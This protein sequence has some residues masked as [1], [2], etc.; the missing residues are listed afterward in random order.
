MPSRQR[1]IRKV[2]A[3]QEW[4]DQYESDDPCLYDQ[5][6]TAYVARG[7]AERAGAAA[8]ALVDGDDALDR[9]KNGPA[10][11]VDAWAKAQTAIRRFSE[12]YGAATGGVSKFGRALG[13]RYGKS[14][15]R[16]SKK[17]ATR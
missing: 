9:I 17:K 15:R 5:L 6:V 2:L 3:E 11:G 12:A 8:K 13:R 1:H 14:R 10:S 7:H 16:P 4:I